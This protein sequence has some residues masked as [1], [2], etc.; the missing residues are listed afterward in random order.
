MN[1]GEIFQ[2]LE[3]LFIFACGEQIVHLFDTY[4]TFNIYFSNWNDVCPSPS[5]VN[6]RTFIITDLLQKDSNLSV[7]QMKHCTPNVLNTCIENLDVTTVYILYSWTCMAEDFHSDRKSYLAS[8]FWRS[9]CVVLSFTLNTIISL[10]YSLVTNHWFAVLNKYYCNLSWKIMPLL[11]F[12]FCM[13]TAIFRLS[14][15]KTANKQPLYIL[16]ETK[17]DKIAP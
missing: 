17:L 13:K 7:S 16:N 2:Y 5:K 1:R 10:I 12:Y 9:T 6:N 4:S 14:K 3:F 8:V 15:I 11:C